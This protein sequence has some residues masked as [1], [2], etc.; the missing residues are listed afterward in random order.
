MITLDAV[1]SAY[2]RRLGPR[3]CVL[4]EWHLTTAKPASVC[5][6]PSY[7]LLASL[8]IIQGSQSI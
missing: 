7:L 5:T 6:Q 1:I 3:A 4:L 8:N 2:R